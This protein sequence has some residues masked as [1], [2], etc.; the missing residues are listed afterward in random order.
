MQVEKIYQVLVKAYHKQ[1]V[2]KHTKYFDTEEKANIHK[3]ELS[4]YLWNTSVSIEVKPVYSVND[5]NIKY[6]LNGT[7]VSLS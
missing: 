1:E 3:Q 5:G 7:F 2:P 4:G 6:L